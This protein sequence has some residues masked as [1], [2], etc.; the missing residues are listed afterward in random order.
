MGC[1]CKDNREAIEQGLKYFE[2]LKQL[3]IKRM[4][5]DSKTQDRRRKD[6]NQAIF[7]YYSNEYI[8][9]VNKYSKEYEKYGLSSLTVSP[10][11]TYQ[12]WDE[13]TMDMVLQCFDNAV[14]DWRKTWCDVD[15]CTRK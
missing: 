2:T 5:E 8:E 14:K 7:H 15:G 9:T 6:F 1:S 13:I 3:F 4:T 11:D 12:V 10:E